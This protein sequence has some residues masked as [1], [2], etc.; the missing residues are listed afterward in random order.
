ML[1]ES[2]LLEWQAMTNDALQQA[3]ANERSKKWKQV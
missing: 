1:S 3:I 2:S